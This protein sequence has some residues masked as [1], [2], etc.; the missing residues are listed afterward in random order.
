MQLWELTIERQSDGEIHSGF[1]HSV[2]LFMFVEFYGFNL[3]NNIHNRLVGLLDSLKAINK[4][5]HQS[6]AQ[7]MRFSKADKK[8]C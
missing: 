4:K 1:S 2:R 8:N 5:G 7:L 6:I 3:L